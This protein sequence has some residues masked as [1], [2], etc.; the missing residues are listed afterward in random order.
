[1]VYVSNLSFVTLLMSFCV[2]A[3]SLWVDIEVDESSWALLI[4]FKYILMYCHYSGQL[5]PLA[6]AFFFFKI[7]P[8]TSYKLSDP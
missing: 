4:I 8:D 5:L 2:V 7:S 6:P 3:L 1:M